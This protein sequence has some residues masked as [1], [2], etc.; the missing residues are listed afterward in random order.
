VICFALRASV[1]LKALSRSGRKARIGPMAEGL[2]V[3]P[4][5]RRNGHDAS[6]CARARSV[7][8]L[9][10]GGVGVPCV[11]EPQGRLLAPLRHR[12]DTA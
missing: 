3:S 7:A 4:S 5:N 11:P 2:G 1:T 10:D 9:G 8:R 6:C 12:G